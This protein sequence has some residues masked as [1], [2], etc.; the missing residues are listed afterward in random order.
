V[1]TTDNPAIEPDYYEIE[2]ALKKIG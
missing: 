1:W 2:Q